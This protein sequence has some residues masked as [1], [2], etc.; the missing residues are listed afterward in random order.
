MN[1]PKE[2]LVMS[3]SRNTASTFAVFQVGSL[4]VHCPFPCDV[5]AV[6]LVG[7]PLLAPSDSNSPDRCPPPR[8]AQR[9]ERYEPKSRSR[10]TSCCCRVACLDVRNVGKVAAKRS[11]SYCWPTRPPSKLNDYLFSI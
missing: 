6:F 3:Q 2:I 1:V 5:L 7:T 11:S 8:K 9:N 10:N 4:L